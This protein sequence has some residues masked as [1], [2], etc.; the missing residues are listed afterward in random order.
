MEISDQSKAKVTATTI[1]KRSGNNMN[2]VISEIYRISQKD[3]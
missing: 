1:I 3:I 2:N